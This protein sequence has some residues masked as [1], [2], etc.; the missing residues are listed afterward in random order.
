MLDPTPVPGASGA[1][2]AWC[3]NSAVV[4][5]ASRSVFAGSEDGALYRWDLA[6]NALT[7]SVQLTQPGPQA[8]TPSVVGPDGLIFAIANGTLYAAGR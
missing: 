2:Y 6:A 3:V 5:A 1:T 4:D 8:Y 7:Q